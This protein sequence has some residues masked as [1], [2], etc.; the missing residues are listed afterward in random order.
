ME[1]PPVAEARGYVT[2]STDPGRVSLG[3]HR[4]GFPWLIGFSVV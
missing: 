3:R 2:D 1:N 4:V